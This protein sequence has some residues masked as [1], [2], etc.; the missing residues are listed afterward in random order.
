MLCLT[1]A[2]ACKTSL[3]W[4]V[5][6]S[7]PPG[8][9]LLPLNSHTKETVSAALV[10]QHLRTI[11]WLD[12][13]PHRT[14]LAHAVDD[15]RRPLPLPAQAAEDVHRSPI[16][17]AKERDRSVPQNLNFSQARSSCATESAART[18]VRVKPSS[19]GPESRAGKVVPFPPTGA[20]DSPSYCL[21]ALRHSVFPECYPMCHT[22]E[23]L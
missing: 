14:A 18:R 22:R 13:L 5:S 23:C 3:E 20:V 9:R 2:R 21:T 10:L 8:A 12:I 19:Q 4:R 11:N 7:H 15:V 16:A 1:L 17:H 6:L